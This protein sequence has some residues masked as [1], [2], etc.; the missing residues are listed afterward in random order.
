MMIHLGADD[1]VSLI[2]PDPAGMAIE[3]AAGDTVTAGGD[4]GLVTSAPTGQEWF[5]F[6][7]ADSAWQPPAIDGVQLVEGW[8]RR[9]AFGGADSAGQRFVQWL[10]GRGSDTDFSGALIPVAIV[11]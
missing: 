2:Y 10:L 5:I 7:V 6:L 1:A 3:V 4:I 9:Y 11:R 8:A